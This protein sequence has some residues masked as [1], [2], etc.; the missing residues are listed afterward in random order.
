MLPALLAAAGLCQPSLAKAQILSLRPLRPL[1]ST[2]RYGGGVDTLICRDLTGDGKLDM[3]FT[4][5][6]GGTAGDTAWVVLRQSGEG[7]RVAFRQLDV[8]KVGL[9]RA[10]RDLVESMPVYRRNDANCCPSGGFDHRRLHWNGRTFV[11]V[12]AWH[13]RKFR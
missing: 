2:V 10:G 4:V 3:A 8:Y 5:F 12:R 9:T 7:W 11:V 1:V 13:D 6:S